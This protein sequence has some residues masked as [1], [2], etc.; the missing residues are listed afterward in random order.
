M[1][2]DD[3]NSTSKTTAYNLFRLSLDT[4]V[5]LGYL[6]LHNLELV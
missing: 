1:Y 4:R 3:Y 6:L 5:R 2:T